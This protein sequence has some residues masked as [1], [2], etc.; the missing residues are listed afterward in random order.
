MVQDLLLDPAPPRAMTPHDPGRRTILKALGASAGAA[1]LAPFLSDEG[2]LAFAELQRTGEAAALKVL[3]PGE[4]TTLEALVEAIIPADERS[5]GA[6]AARV[7]EYVDLL[8]GE[9]EETAREEW[10]AGLRAVEAEAQA[11]FG[12]AFAGLRPEGA[13]TLLTEWSA[14][15]KAP[16]SPLEVFFNTTKDA[17]ITGYYTSEIGIHQ[18]LRYKGNTFTPEF[19]GCATEDGRDCPHCGRKAER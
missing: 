8:L 19:V 1:A 10:R 17:T 16:E 11:R 6:R 5:P 18:E 13:V 2:L 4:F 12:A 9:S 14:R 15:E 7:A 3:S